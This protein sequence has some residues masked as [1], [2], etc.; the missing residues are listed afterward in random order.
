MDRYEDV[1]PEAP[2]DQIF[3]LDGNIPVRTGNL[4]EDDP[5]IWGL[6]GFADAIGILTK[7]TIAN[8]LADM[9]RRAGRLLFDESWVRNQGKRG[10]CN[11]YACSSILEK[12]RYNRGLS[13]VELGPEWLYANI[14]GG[15]DRG[16][17]LKD[18]IMSM[19]RDGVPRREL[20]PYESFR[21]PEQKPEAK[22]DAQRFRILPG[23]YFGVSTED[24]MASA[25]AMGFPVL[26]AVHV[27]NAWMKLDGDGVVGATDGPGNHAIH[28]DDLRIKNGEYQFDHQGSWGTRYG[29]QGRGW[30]TWRKHLRTTVRYHQFVAVRSTTDD[31]K[32]AQLPKKAA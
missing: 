30:I 17:L 8:I 12:A 31:P 3:W 22:E 19:E 14:N 26:I 6:Q 2:D 15:V 10:S 32:E 25:L 24:E 1:P 28:C 27:A 21:K 16:S 20:V 13:K 29:Q 5:F 18:G 11:A 9:K 23:E 4:L 7:D